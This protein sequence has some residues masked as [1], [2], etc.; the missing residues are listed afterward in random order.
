MWNCSS[1]HGCQCLFRLAAE[2]GSCRVFFHRL[3]ECVLVHFQHIPVLAL[4]EAP[5]VGW[6]L[7]NR[8]KKNTAYLQGAS[9][10]GLPANIAPHLGI[11]LACLSSFA[12][13]D[14]CEHQS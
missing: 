3:R 9:V 5:S 4:G 8:F 2:L 11:S 1:G 10:I 7:R 12:Q 13:A 14:A 6:R